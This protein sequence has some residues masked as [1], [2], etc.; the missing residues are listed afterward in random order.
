MSSAGF[1]DFFRAAIF[2]PLFD[3]GKQFEASSTV[4]A[5]SFNSDP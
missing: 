5:W 2:L 1:V 4:F 3:L